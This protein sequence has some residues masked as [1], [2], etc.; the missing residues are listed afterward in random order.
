MDGRRTKPQLTELGYA[1]KVKYHMKKKMVFFCGRFAFVGF[2]IVLHF[3]VYFTFVEKSDLRLWRG[4]YLWKIGLHL[5][6]FYV[7][8]QVYV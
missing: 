2:K 4:L 7:C 1:V 8:G 5:W 3:Q 6:V